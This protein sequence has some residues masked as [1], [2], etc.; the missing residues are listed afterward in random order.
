MIGANTLIDRFGF[1]WRV[2][3]VFRLPDDF[4]WTGYALN[5]GIDG[6]LILCK[7]LLWPKGSM[8]RGFHDN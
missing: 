7:R 6:G 3:H 2:R 5:S 1:I 4:I 8:T